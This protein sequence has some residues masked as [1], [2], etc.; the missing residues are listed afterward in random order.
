MRHNRS[1]T[2]IIEN[3]AATEV[4]DLVK[5]LNALNDYGEVYY[6]APADNQLPQEEL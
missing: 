1:V 3:V 6:K 4:D 2:L 5:S